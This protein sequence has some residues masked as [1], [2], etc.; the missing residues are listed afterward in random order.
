MIGQS[1][2]VHVPINRNTTLVGDLTVPEGARGVILFAHGGGGSRHSSRNKFVASTFQ[3]AGFST[4]LF[5]LLTID[6]DRDYIKR[7]EIA[8]LSERLM[9]VTDWLRSQR[10]FASFNIG[11]FGASTGAAATFEA[12]ALLGHTVKAI[13]SRGGRPDLAFRD[14]PKVKSPT[15]LVVGSED[16]QVL[17]LN[18]WAMSLL[19]V[20]KELMIIEGATHLFEEPGKLEEVA[21]S[22]K[23]WFLKYMKGVRV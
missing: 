8:L 4:L 19:G 22:S 11:Y 18:R 16:E 12:A 3:Q 6:E 9:K 23:N 13:V 14:L 21:E 5:D 10:P 17:N 1:E 20:E 15:L 2:E 7:F